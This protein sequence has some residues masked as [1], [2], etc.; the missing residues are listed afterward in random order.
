ML[1]LPK[2][3]FVLTEDLLEPTVPPRR[4]PVLPAG[5]QSVT[6]GQHINTTARNALTRK[7]PEPTE[8]PPVAMAAK[9][10]RL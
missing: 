4:L 10:Q 5:P 9:Q 7:L 6:A 3:H 1:L 8:M 2:R